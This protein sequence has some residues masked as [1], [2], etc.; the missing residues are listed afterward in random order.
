M[1]AKLHVD[2]KEKGGA[3]IRPNM[4]ILNADG[5]SST[6]ARTDLSHSVMSELRFFNT[7]IHQSNF[8]GCAFDDCDFDGTTI[9]GSSFRGVQLVNCDVDHMVINGVNIGSLMRLLSG[10]I[11][12]KHG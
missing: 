2:D 3:P 1:A 7:R 6:V 8:E 9:S 12:G 10:P 4:M 11:G 5:R